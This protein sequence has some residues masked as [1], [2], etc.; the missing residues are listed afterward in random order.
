MLRTPACLPIQAPGGAFL[1]ALP[2]TPL[3]PPLQ[4]IKTRAGIKVLWPG[5]HGPVP[6][7][8]TPSLPKVSPRRKRTIPS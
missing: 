3:L 4:P 7:V 5:L 8:P 6:P 1:G 2:H